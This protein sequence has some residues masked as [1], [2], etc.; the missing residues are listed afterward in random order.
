VLGTRAGASLVT[1]LI[2][3]YGVALFIL[4]GYALY[5]GMR[6][7]TFR[8]EL[9]LTGYFGAAQMLVAVLSLAALNYIPAAMMGFLFY[10]FPASVAIIAAVTRTERLTPL[11]MTALFL[12]LAGIVV[13]VGAPWTMG[14]NIRGVL[15]AL[16]AGTIYAV[17]LVSLNRMTSDV[18]PVMTT[19]YISLGAGL[20]CVV[21]G[22]ATDSIRAL[23]LPAIAFAIL[24]LAIVS[25][26]LAFL[27]FLRG[28]SVLGS[29][30]TSIVSTVE[31]F[32]TALLGAVVLSQP[33]TTGTLAGG[34]LIAVAV[35]MLVWRP[36]RVPLSEAT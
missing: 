14:G 15:L 7:P 29:V 34:L 12:S 25:T 27:A 33:V 5:R 4:V 8:M 28:L 36:E 9:L 26:V 2:G 19:T 21:F 23:P 30:R 22:M 20:Y 16:G 17:Y 18:H 3:R 24:G 31:P 11:K 10:T 32:W 1:L 6:R 13:M 35:I